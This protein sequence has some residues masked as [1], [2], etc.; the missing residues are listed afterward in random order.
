MLKVITL[1]ETVSNVTANITA[2]L[3]SHNLLVHLWSG[4]GSLQV[5]GGAFNSILVLEDTPSAIA[6]Q[7]STLRYM[8]PLHYDGMDYIS[9]N[10]SYADIPSTNSSTKAVV[11]IAG[12]NHAPSFVPATTEVNITKTGDWLITEWA[13]NISAGPINEQWQAVSFIVTRLS[14]T[15]TQFTTLPNVSSNGDLWISVSESALRAGGV[16]LFSVMAVDDG[17][18]ANG[19]V[20]VSDPIILTIRVITPPDQV[21]LTVTPSHVSVIGG[22]YVIITFSHFRFDILQVYLC[23]IQADIVFAYDHNITVTANAATD[24]C[25]G[26]V[27]IRLDSGDVII[28]NSSFTYEPGMFVV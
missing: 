19:G 21:I 25:T 23:D 7:L 5:A 26:N 16:A 2:A 18:T 12:I 10:V 14:D 1:Q 28:W 22:E 20:N 13:R 17:G 11:G 27:S 8:P 15:F 6:T 4:L 9:A 24:I 3:Q